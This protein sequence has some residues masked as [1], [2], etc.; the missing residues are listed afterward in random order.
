[1]LLAKPQ[2]TFPSFSAHTIQNCLINVKEHLPM[3]GR[4]E[5]VFWYKYSKGKIM[6]YR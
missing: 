3:F 2:D 5:Y 1:M 4:D 6:L